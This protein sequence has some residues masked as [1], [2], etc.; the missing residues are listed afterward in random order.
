MPLQ[1]CPSEDIYILVTI[2]TCNF[3][4]LPCIALYS[5]LLTLVKFFITH[6]VYLDL[7][8]SSSSLPTYCNAVDWLLVAK[9]VKILILVLMCVEVEFCRGCASVHVWVC[10]PTS[11]AHTTFSAPFCFTFSSLFILIWRLN[12]SSFSHIS[13]PL[14]FIGCLEGKLLP[15][16]I[17]R[18]VIGRCLGRGWTWLVELHVMTLRTR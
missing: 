10:E 3:P 9:C 2:L 16:I 14:H 18:H 8:H 5:Y 1:S 15:F 12:S 4:S 6:S 13:N 17:P 11:W 7:T